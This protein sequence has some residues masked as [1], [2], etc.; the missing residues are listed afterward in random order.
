[1]L[2][3]C[4]AGDISIAALSYV[5]IVHASSTLFKSLRFFSLFA[6]NPSVCCVISY[7]TN[8]NCTSVSTPAFFTTVNIPTLL[9][10][11]CLRYMRVGWP[12]MFAVAMLHLLFRPL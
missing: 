6:V 12:S 3:S 5:T 1:M 4:I 7:S 10:S 2:L 11:I 9:A 8:A